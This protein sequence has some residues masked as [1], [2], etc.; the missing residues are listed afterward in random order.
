M[1]EI[2]LCDFTSQVGS[3]EAVILQQACGT[4]AS[5]PSLAVTD[6]GT[7]SRPVLPFMLK[8]G[9]EISRTCVFEL[10]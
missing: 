1:Q 5:V 3:V 7:K 2:P 8:L 9:A 4:Y 6:S 10:H